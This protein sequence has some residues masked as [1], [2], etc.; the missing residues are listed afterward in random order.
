MNFQFN[1]EKIFHSID[2]ILQ[3]QYTES[4]FY[5]NLTKTKLTE[6]QHNF[7][8]LRLKSFV[9]LFREEQQNGQTTQRNFFNPRFIGSLLLKKDPTV[10]LT[11]LAEGFLVHRN[12][13]S[14]NYARELW[15]KCKVNA[16]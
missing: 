6:S 13:P 12:W 11:A 1:K 10:Q 8:S 7:F 16:F 5:E 2:G 14:T 9:N 15:E 4:H 3:M